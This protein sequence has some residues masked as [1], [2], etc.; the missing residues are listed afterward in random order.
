MTRIL[1]LDDEPTMLQWLGLLLKRAGY[2]QLCAA[3]SKTAL[4]LLQREPIDLL[5]QDCLRPE[6]DGEQFYY[7]LKAD[8]QLRHIPVLFISARQHPTLMTECLEY[9]DNYI[10]KNYSPPEMLKAI[11]EILLRHGKPIPAEAG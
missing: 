10:T 3:D 2:E 9:G 4:S 1:T 6:I 5:T 7:I 8:K 11:K